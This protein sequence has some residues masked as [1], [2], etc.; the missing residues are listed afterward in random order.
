MITITGGKE[1]YI[2]WKLK[3]FKDEA[4]AILESGTVTMYKLSEEELRKYN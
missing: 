2:G 1:S 3:N 4:R